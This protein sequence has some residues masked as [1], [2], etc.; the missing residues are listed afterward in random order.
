MSA[1]LLPHRTACNYLSILFN[2]PFEEI[3][4]IFLALQYYNY[5]V[6]SATNNYPFIFPNKGA[7]TLQIVAFIAFYFYNLALAPPPTFL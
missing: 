1:D 4:N 2:Y 7:P 5:R 6:V 3:Y